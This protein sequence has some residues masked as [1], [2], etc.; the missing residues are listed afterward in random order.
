MDVQRALLAGVGDCDGSHVA[1]SSIAWK[2]TAGLLIEHVDSVLTRQACG[3]HEP[4]RSQDSA[5]GTMGV[6]CAAPKRT[7]AMPATRM[8][9]RPLGPTM[10]SLSAGVWVCAD[11]GGGWGLAGD[12]KS[13]V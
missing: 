13:V 4:S 6:V 11:V 9:K 7:A 10:V 3:E 1:W 2:S 5:D 12:R 8:P